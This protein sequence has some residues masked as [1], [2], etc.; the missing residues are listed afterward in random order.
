MPRCN[1]NTT[2]DER[3]RAR[4]AIIT[5]KK[6]RRAGWMARLG[7]TT[8]PL[9]YA[10]PC[11][12]GVPGQRRR[13]PARFHDTCRLLTPRAGDGHRMALEAGAKVVNGDVLLAPS[14]KLFEEGAILVNQEGKRFTN[15]LARPALAIPRQPERVAFIL[16]DAVVAGKFS[17]WPYFISTAPGT[18]YAYLQD[19]RVN[20]KDI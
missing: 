6:G 20:R 9:L 13:P 10:P 11:C 3:F 12:K 14:P 19:Y 8:Q 15:E 17:R 4:G 5:P 18:A 2:E 16:F 7:R 1:R